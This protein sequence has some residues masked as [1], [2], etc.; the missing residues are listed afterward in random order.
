MSRRTLPMVEIVCHGYWLEK[1]LLI[2][3][4]VEL[5]SCRWMGG[6]EGGGKCGEWK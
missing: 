3:F 6:W 2:L 4:F 1:G 5:W